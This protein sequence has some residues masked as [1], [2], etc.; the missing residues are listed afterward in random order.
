[1]AAGIEAEKWWRPAVFAEKIPHLQR[2]ARLLADLRGFL[3]GRGYLEVETSAL[4]T[5]PGMEVHVKAFETQLYT[6]DRMENA[7][8]FLQTSP[9]IAMKKLLVAGVPKIFQICQVFRNAEGSPLHRPSFTMLEWYAAGMEYRDLMKEATD[10]IRHCAGGKKILWGGKTS[11]PASDWQ[12]IS[13]AESFQT[14]AG[15]DLGAVL[16]DVDAFAAAARAADVPPHEGDGWE[17]IF[18]RVF[19]EKI[20]SHLGHPAPSILYDYPASMAAL[21]RKKPEDPQF[22]E[23]FEIY[24]C[25]VELANAFGE[26][27]DAAEQKSR[28]EKAMTEKKEIYGEDYPVDMDFIA[29][30]EYGMPDCSGIALGVDRLAMLLSGAEDIAL[31]TAGG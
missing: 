2:R 18:F 5:S 7:R 1:M 12:M 14:Y 30:L 13:V 24:I 9:E 8:R 20:E 6:P 29:A 27:T 23:R 22:A 21:S 17:D 28:F 19:L 4:Q 16:E 15:I 31:V 26:L 11:D 25:G 10:L 3:S